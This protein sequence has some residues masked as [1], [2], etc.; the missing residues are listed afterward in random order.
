MSDL[1]RNHINP[2]EAA[3]AALT[4]C[5]VQTLG[6]SDPTFRSRFEGNLANMY[7]RVRDNGLFFEAPALQTLNLVRDLLKQE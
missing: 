4:V 3:I 5:I 7:S 6:G 1:P 2:T